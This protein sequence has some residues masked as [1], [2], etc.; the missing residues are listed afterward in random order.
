MY[1]YNKSNNKNKLKDNQLFYRNIQLNM[2]R[3]LTRKVN[4]LNKEYQN[5]QYINKFKN[6]TNLNNIAQNEKYKLKTKI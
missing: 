3:E 1:L 2:N 5:I 4:K 6:I